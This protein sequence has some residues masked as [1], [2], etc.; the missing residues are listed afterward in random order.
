M[1]IDSRPILLILMVFIVVAFIPAYGLDDTKNGAFVENISIRGIAACLAGVVVASFFWWLIHIG[2]KA[3]NRLNKGEMRRAVAGAFVIGFHAIVLLYIVLSPESSRDFVL[4]YIEFVG[5]VVGFY[6]GS[7]T[8]QQ[9]RIEVEELVIENVVLEDSRLKIS[10][11]NLTSKAVTVDRVYVNGK[12]KSI[13]PKVV[14]PLSVEDITL[15]I[16][17][18][19]V[20]DQN[21]IKVTTKSG[22]SATWEGSI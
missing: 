5:L 14:N 1:K 18:G 12:P 19:D 8:A 13:D 21:R 2:Y 20:K 22:E 17:R 10:V 15:E 3:D 9:Q 6:F 4:A 11:R 7:R 16:D